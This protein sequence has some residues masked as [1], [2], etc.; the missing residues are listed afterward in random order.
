MGFTIVGRR[1]NK[2]EVHCLSCSPYWSKCHNPH[3]WYSCVVRVNMVKTDTWYKYSAIRYR[4]KVLNKSTFLTQYSETCFKRN[5]GK[6]G[7]TFTVQRPWTTD[8]SN[9]KELSCSGKNFGAFPFRYRQVAMCKVWCRCGKLYGFLNC[10][11]SAV[12]CVDSTV[13][14]SQELLT[15]WCGP[16]VQFAPGFVCLCIRDG[17]TF[18]GSPNTNSAGSM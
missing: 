5:I 8:D 4:Q 6:Q 12:W 10:R 16:T 7:K 15:S 1:Q 14:C 13:R 3:G 17:V 9:L 11:C 18:Y 2:F